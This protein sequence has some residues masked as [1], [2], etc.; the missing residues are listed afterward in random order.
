MTLPEAQ[1]PQMR[2][3]PIPRTHHE[4]PQRTLLH[5]EAGYTEEL[6]RSTMSNRKKS[7][8]SLGASIHGGSAAPPWK[9]YLCLPER[10]RRA[11]LGRPRAIHIYEQKGVIRMTLAITQ[12]PPSA[13]AS[14]R[15]WPGC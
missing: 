14:R 1:T 9:P 13:S 2:F 7:L 15:A 4:G 12:P 8:A 3:G 10:K 11:R 6:D 5:K